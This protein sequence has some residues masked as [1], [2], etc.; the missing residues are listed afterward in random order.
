M[1]AL[2]MEEADERGMENRQ[3]GLALRYG[4]T[5][6]AHSQVPSTSDQVPTKDHEMVVHVSGSV[7]GLRD[8]ALSSFLVAQMVADHH[9]TWHFETAPSASSLEPNRVEWSFELHPQALG[10][11][12]QFGAVGNSSYGASQSSE[13]VLFGVHRSVTAKARLYL[14]GQYQFEVFSQST[15]QGGSRDPNLI[16]LVAKVTMS[17]FDNPN[18]P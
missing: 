12:R 13:K 5:F 4:G 9:A 11:V 10:A 1:H 6:A 2:E 16:A 18:A 7:P 15:I 8:S 14:D 3:I 17:L